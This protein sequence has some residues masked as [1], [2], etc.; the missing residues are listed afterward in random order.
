MFEYPGQLFSRIFSASLLASLAAGCDEPPPPAA[1]TVRTGNP[2]ALAVYREEGAADWQA[3]V[4]AEDGTL[5]FSPAGPYRVVIACEPRTTGLSSVEIVQYA[6]TPEDGPSIE[7]ACAPADHP[8][9]LR[10]RIAQSG[11][12]YFGDLSR[13]G[14]D[15]DWELDIPAAPGSYDLVLRVGERIAI[16]RGIEISGDTQL[17][18]IDLPPDSTEALISTTFTVS[19]PRDGELISASTRLDT[20]STI[21]IL[22][23]AMSGSGGWTTKLA[24]ESALLATDRQT[25]IFMAA[26]L[27][28]APGAQNHYRTLER[29]VRVGDP[30]SAALPEPLGEVA[31][32]VAGDRLT[33]TWAALPA[34]DEVALRWHSITMS[35]TKD[36][37]V[38]L[39]RSFLE[40]TGATSAALELRDIPG[41]KDEWRHEPGS[42]QAHVLT[43]RR[44]GEGEQ[45]LSQVNEWIYPGPTGP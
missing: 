41:L 28:G 26:L 38:A 39:S 16:R 10:A 30:T 43:A 2:P 32:E 1:V 17:G 4:A 31:F 36:H 37:E 9:H 8:F 6:R 7:H 45:A 5:R 12:G 34:H 15:P 20:G 44:G 42:Q 22:Q 40:A 27:G 29:D 33:A 14:F 35:G 21:A 25:A 3:L 11:V 24:P 19:S 18:S 13:A 23:D